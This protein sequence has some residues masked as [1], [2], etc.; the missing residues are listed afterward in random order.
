M[1]VIAHPRHPAAGIPDDSP[2]L[3]NDNLASVKRA[4]ICLVQESESVVESLVSFR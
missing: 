3:T 1:K 4:I 2:K